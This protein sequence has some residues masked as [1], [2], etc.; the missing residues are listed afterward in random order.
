MRCAGLVFTGGQSLFPALA[1][2][3]RFSFVFFSFVSSDVL[4][5]IAQTQLNVTHCAATQ[6]RLIY[7]SHPFQ[8]AKV[9]PS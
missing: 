9:R 6:L 8:A 1:P 5:P 7:Q 3:P 4:T 2:R